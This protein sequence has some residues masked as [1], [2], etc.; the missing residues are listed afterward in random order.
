VK[1]KVKILIWAGI[2]VLIQCL[3]F[4][5]WGCKKEMD[6]AKNH[7]KLGVEYH[8]Q[9]LSDQTMGDSQKQELTE[10]AVNELQEALKID[11]NYAEAHYELGV[12]YQEKA[13]QEGALREIQQ[14]EADYG[15]ALRELQQA[16]KT[17]PDYAEAHFHLGSVYQVLGGYDQAINEFEEVLRINLN[18]PRIHT[19]IG[20]VYYLK[21]ITAYKRAIRLDWWSYLRPDTLKEIPYKDKDELKKAIENYIGAT[22]SDT[23][24]AAAYSKLSQAYY[25]WAQDE[26]QKAI[27][28]DSLDTNA[29]LFLGLTFLERGYPNKAT[30]QYEVLK[31]LD[32]KAANMLLQITQREEQEATEQ[33]KRG[34]K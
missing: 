13:D 15:N 18:F 27:A 21:G 17:N 12:L 6:K 9:I 20:N 30:L 32:P 22:Q 29:Q 3:L 5:T 4:Y 28:V 7:Y 19:A 34:P 14:A 10:K 33:K 26:Y 23:N 2:L 24:N 1:N 31:N 11:P 8:K 16:I 25:T